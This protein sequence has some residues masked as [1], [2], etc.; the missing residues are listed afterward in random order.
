M[1]AT[2]E[3][4]PTFALVKKLGVGIKDEEERHIFK[5]IDEINGHFL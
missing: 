2:P 4:F 1:H 5:R 3:S